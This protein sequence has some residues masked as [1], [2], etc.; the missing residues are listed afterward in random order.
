MINGGGDGTFGLL[1]VGVWGYNGGEHRGLKLHGLMKVRI[2]HVLK[3]IEVVGA[4]I[5]LRMSIWKIIP[6]RR[7][8]FLIRGE[9][10]FKVLRLRFR[11]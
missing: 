3:G 4:I 10:G 7:L 1:L 11:L 9:K 6:Q 2:N 8:Y 5:D